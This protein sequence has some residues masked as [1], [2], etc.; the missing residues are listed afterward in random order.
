MFN[1]TSV[2]KCRFTFETAETEEGIVEERLVEGRLIISASL[3]I[4]VCLDS[5]NLS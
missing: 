1:Y 3:G 5:H 2:W 4:N